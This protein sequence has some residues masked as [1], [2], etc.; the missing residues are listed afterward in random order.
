M[1]RLYA[2]YCFLILIGAPKFAFAEYDGLKRALFKCTEERN[3]ME[4]HCEFRSFIHLQ[5]Q[6]PIYSS[7]SVTE[8]L[9]ASALIFGQKAV[10][11]LSPTDPGTCQ[12]RVEGQFKHNYLAFRLK[13]IQTE[14]KL[15]ECQS[16]CLAICVSSLLI[17]FVEFTPWFTDPDYVFFSEKGRC[18]DYS[19]VA[20][21]LFEALG[22]EGAIEMNSIHSFV[23][24]KV[25]DK[26][27]YAEPQ[28]SSCIFYGD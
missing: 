17:N 4:T 12:N 20:V 1:T 24:V 6:K 14:K 26:W 10:C 2:A 3:W 8:K 19:R 21:A 28:D 25:K 15:S 22:L 16:A 5:E 9:A 23:R 13:K 11:A 27:Y 7:T 18:T